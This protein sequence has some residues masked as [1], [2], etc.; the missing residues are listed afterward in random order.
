MEIE[1]KI[2]SDV[3]VEINIKNTAEHLE[4]QVKSTCPEL[5]GTV[6]ALLV[7]VSKMLKT[8][9]NDLLD[10][11]LEAKKKQVKEAELEMEEVE[12]Q[13]FDNVDDFLDAL[14][15]KK[16]APEEESPEEVKGYTKEEVEHILRK[17]FPSLDE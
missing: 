7:T 5:E 4:I 10:T 15:T 12:V 16:E 14:L 13:E 11:L 2:F 6:A 3:T 8:D 17:L 1:N 9:P